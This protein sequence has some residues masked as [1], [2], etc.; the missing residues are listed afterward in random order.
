MYFKRKCLNF[1]LSLL[2]SVPKGLTDKIT[3]LVQIMAWCWKGDKPLSLLMMAYVHDG[4]M[5]HSASNE[6]TL[7]YNVLI[8]AYTLLKHSTQNMLLNH[9]V[10]NTVRPKQNGCHSADDKFQIHFLEYKLYCNS[11]F[12]DI[13]SQ[14]SNTLN[15]IC[16][17][18]IVCH[19]FYCMYSACTEDI[20]VSFIAPC[21]IKLIWNSFVWEI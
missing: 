6:L 3:A 18:A 7:L 14:G 21:L 8:D 17:I 10:I 19:Q 5:L 13:C 11:N 9:Q 4:Y 20:W 2:R 12:T 16:C 15:R 1:E